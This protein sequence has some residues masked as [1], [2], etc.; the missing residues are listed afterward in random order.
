MEDRI[1]ADRF[2]TLFKRL[3]SSERVALSAAEDSLEKGYVNEYLDSYN[4]GHLVTAWELMSE[5]PVARQRFAQAVNIIIER[6]MELGWVEEYR[7][8]ITGVR[9]N[10]LTAEGNAL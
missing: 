4:P 1:N 10:R 9:K 8:A 6:A 3:N 5:N 7:C 2:L